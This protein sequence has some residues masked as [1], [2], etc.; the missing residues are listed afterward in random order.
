MVVVASFAIPTRQSRLP[1]FPGA[2]PTAAR[3]LL[4]PPG[5][6][7]SARGHAASSTERGADGLARALSPLG[8]A[9]TGTLRGMKGHGQIAE[10]DERPI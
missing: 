7:P 8:A 5:Y 1:G 6:A 10:P 4:L 2:A 9:R 3:H